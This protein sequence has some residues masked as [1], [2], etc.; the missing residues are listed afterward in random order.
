MTTGIPE[1]YKA[2]MLGWITH[3][4]RFGRPQEY[5]S[6]ALEMVRNAYLNGVAFRI[7]GG[8]CG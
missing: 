8:A 6:L 1:A 5:A 7:E 4:R 2:D 3:P